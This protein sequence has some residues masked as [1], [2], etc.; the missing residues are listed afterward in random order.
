MGTA[1]TTI[2]KLIRRAASSYTAGPTIK[3]ARAACER[4]ASERIASTVCYWNNDFDP[5]LFVAGSYLR[6]IDI[7]RG[8]PSESYLSV[9][10]PAFGFTLD[11]LKK[12]LEA[13]RRINT[14][15]HFDAMAPDSVDKT[16]ILIDQARRIYR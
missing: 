11:L 10:A 15:V 4:F 14:T 1:A 6:L 12:I 2:Q 7:I 3:D 8:L 5:P 9:K 13:A 16:F